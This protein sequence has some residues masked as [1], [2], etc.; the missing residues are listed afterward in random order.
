LK[1]LND[2]GIKQLGDV[3]CGQMKRECD[4]LI[5]EDSSDIGR[6]QGDYSLKLSKFA[7]IIPQSDYRVTRLFND[8]FPPNTEL[9][10]NRRNQQVLVVWADDVPVVVDVLI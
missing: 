2:L 9:F 1:A 5:P 7:P 4:V 10:P 8:R 6:I 3:L